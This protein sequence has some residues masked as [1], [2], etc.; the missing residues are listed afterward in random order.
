MQKNL[1]KVENH[2]KNLAKEDSFSKQGIQNSNSL[3]RKEQQIYK[4][5]GTSQTSSQKRIQSANMNK[6]PSQEK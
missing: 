6:K 3:T 1:N 4:T 5:M 2:H